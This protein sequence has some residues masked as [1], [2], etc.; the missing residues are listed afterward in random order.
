MERIWDKY[1]T[2]LDR[3]VYELSGWGKAAGFGDKPALLVI[4]VQ[5][6]TVGE[7]KPILESMKKWP[8]SCGE[9]AWQAVRKIKI[10][11][12]EARRNKLPVIYANVERASEFEVGPWAG[13]IP[14]F[15]DDIHRVGHI[16]TKNVEEIAPIAGEIVI[17][18]RYVSAFFGTPL[19]TYLNQL[20]VDT[21]IITGCT[22][23][24][25]IRGTA[26]DAFSYAFKVIVPEDCVY[27]RGEVTH[28]LN[29]FDINAK[30]GDVITMEKVREK[31]VSLAQTA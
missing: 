31:I 6:R 23:S 5:Y 20:G 10:L 14:S 3:K 13:K 7:D 25:C 28:A 21:L 30:Y 29:L 4:D 16:G 24:G 8:T 19:M 18:K 17:S 26:I 9:K 11:L 12:E 22:T 1:I 15:T 27:D 2:D